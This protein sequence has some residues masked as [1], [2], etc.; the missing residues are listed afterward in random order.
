MATEMVVRQFQTS[1]GESLIALW[2]QVLPDSQPWNA[3]KEALIRK[4]NRGDGLVFVAEQAG[5]IVGA[6]KAGYDG[7]RG[8]IYSLAVL[9]D[10]RRNGTGRKLLHAA[11][12]ALSDR[13]CPKVN[14]QVRSS[15]S[16]VVELYRRCGYRMEERTSLG[17]ALV[18][19]SHQAADSFS[20]FV[21]PTR[22]RC[23]RFHGTT[24]PPI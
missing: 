22:S 12:S 6:V 24:G 11:E 15:N 2:Q 17:K 14:L 20:N 4:L 8:W 1:D 23:H 3:P 9:P 19:D 7:V 21:F 10:Q 5:S 13:G 18:D 16:E